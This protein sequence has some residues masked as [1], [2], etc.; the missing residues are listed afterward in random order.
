MRSILLVIGLILSCG[1]APGALAGSE[2]DEIAFFESK[3][4]PI[5]SERCFEC[6]S[7]GKKVKGGLALDTRA[8]WA[9]GGDAGPAIVPGKPHE[10]LLITAIGWRDLDLQMPPKQQLSERERQVLT[11]WVQRGAHD[12]RAGA[13]QAPAKDRALGIE[14]GRTFWAYA[15]LTSATPPA[16]QDAGWARTPIDHFILAGLEA[17]GLRPAAD[18]T[19][20]ALVR[21]LVFSLTGLPPSPQQVDRFVARAGTNGTTGSNR[22][23]AVDEL[24]AE[25]LATPAFAERWAS[26]W[27]DLTRFAESSGGGRTLLFKDAWRF[28]DYVVQ[29]FAENRPLDQMIR[30]H[31][32]GDLLPAASPQERARQLTA[33]AFLAL[34]PTIYEEQ[35]K[36]RLRFD[37]ID[38]QLDTIGKAF[39]GQTIGCARCHDH[40]FDPILQRDYY[41]LAGI[42]ASTRTLS[43]YTDNVVRWIDAPLPLAAAEE[44]AITQAAS[45]LESAQKRLKEAKNEVAR[46]KDVASGLS[47]KTNQP[48]PLSELAGIVIDDAQAQASGQWKQSTHSPHF[49]GSGYRHDDGKDKGAKT[50]TF[51]PRLPA[52]GRYEVRLAY[53]ALAGRSTRVPVHIF[54]AMGE[55]TVFVDQTRTPDLENRFVSLGTFTFEQ[56]GDSYVIVSNEGTTGYVTADLVQFLPVGATPAA[57]ATKAAAEPPTVSTLRAEISRLE[58]Q[59]AELTAITESR[60]LTMSVREEDTVGDT[61]IRIRGE[62]HQKAALV[63]RGF[64]SVL[65]HGTTTLPASQSGRRELADW[66]VSSRNPLT[67]RV[68]VNRVW[69]W[70]AGQ[71]LVRTVDNFGTTGEAPS[72]P[73]L[74]DHLARRFQ[75]GGWNLQALIRDIVG[76]RTWQL[77]VASAPADPDNRWWSHA[78]RRRLDAEQIRDALLTVSGALD[79]TVGGANIRGAN[80]AASESAAASAVEFGYQFT[81]LR[82]SLYTPAFRNN[83]LELFAL[84]DFGDINSSQG[85]RHTSTVA[86]QALYFLNHPFV[87]E[88]A[89][90]AAQRALAAAGTPAQRLASAF[91]HCLGRTPLPAETAACTALLQEG[92]PSEEAWTMIFQTLFGSVAFRYLD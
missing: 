3:V 43:N 81:D 17:R 78:Q 23:Q 80:T 84:F 13:A 42:F 92:A 82:R 34:G 33:T 87:L 77:A 51:T 27:L 60:P 55:V 79:R 12:P 74:L 5:L 76:S 86:P 59:V 58:K 19:P 26:H 57:L 49:F 31:I 88:Q 18:A 65:S 47:Q 24:T 68:L 36:Q 62:V 10:S 29:S 91:T 63:P 67:A 90:L 2:A 38:E 73:E 30:E 37:V 71:G 20:V 11:E 89:K 72:H 14:A 83:R 64:L 44:K 32:A 50:L 40:K 56:D 69:A 61:H 53:P 46:F 66:L 7:T 28:R 52:S 25:L 4:R 85:Q 21:R 45:Q 6:H 75:E 35:D 39:L 9:K 15:P 41:A 22:A 70:L 1:G 16:V 48:I 8:D 54:H